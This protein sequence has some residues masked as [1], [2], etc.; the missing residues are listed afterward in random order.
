MR[1]Q[2]GVVLDRRQLQSEPI[3]TV[4]Q[5]TVIASLHSDVSFPITIDQLKRQ[6]RPETALAQH[7]PGDMVSRVL[8]QPR[9]VNCPNVR[10]VRQPLGH[11]HSILA[12]LAHA[13]R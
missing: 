7:A 10:M 5:H 8:L 2:T 13:Q 9:I 12:L 1:E 6:H 4:G 3:K 11:G